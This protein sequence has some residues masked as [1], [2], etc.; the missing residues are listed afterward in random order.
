MAWIDRRFCG[1]SPCAAETIAA[2]FTAWRARYRRA[3]MPP[4]GALSAVASK[5][6]HSASSV[7][8][9]IVFGHESALGFDD[10][11]AEPLL[12]R[13][14][15]GLVPVD[16]R[17]ACEELRDLVRANAQAQLA[18]ATI[19]VPALFETLRETTD[20]DELV[21]LALEALF[22]SASAAHVM[23]DGTGELVKVKVHDAIAKDGGNIA[24]LIGELRGGDFYS[25]LYAAQTLSEVSETRGEALRAK[26]LGDPTAISTLMDATR[27]NEV[28][29]NEALLLL[30][31]L[32]RG[33]E[34]LQKLVAFE[35]AFERAFSIIAEEGGGDGGIVVQDCL[36]LCNNLLRDAPSNQTLFRENGF[37]RNV[38][39]LAVVERSIG[40]DGANV[41][42]AQKCANT[43]C[44]LET[45]HLLVSTDEDQTKREAIRVDAELEVMMI[46]QRI[47]GCRAN[48]TELAKY[49]TVDILIRAALGDTAVKVASVRIAALRA[50]AALVRDHDGNQTALFSAS[51]E[52]AGTVTEPALLSC[53]RTALHGETQSERDAAALV[54]GAAMRGNPEGQILLVSTLAPTGYGGPDGTD[55]SSLGG[56]L[57]R[58]LMPKNGAS[59]AFDQA[60]VAAAGILREMLHRNDQSRLKALRVNLEGVNARSSSSELLLPRCV[61][62]LA[63]TFTNEDDK[64]N[65]EKL[66][67]VFL[68]LLIV[69]LY[70]CAPAV[71]AFLSSPGHLPAIADLA[72][73]GGCT[74]SQHVAALACV[75]LGCC[76]LENS[77]TVLDVVSA[78]VGLQNFFM[79]WESMTTSEFYVNVSKKP[80]LPKPLTRANAS[81]LAN[82][83]CEELLEYAPGGGLYDHE[84]TIFINDLEER[85]KSSIMSLY[86]KP[87]GAADE[88]ATSTFAKRVDEDDAGYLVRLQQAL[89][90][91]QKD[92]SVAQA[93]NAVLA[94]QLLNGTRSDAPAQD[95][96]ARGSPES[97]ARNASTEAL[98]SAVEAAKRASA[99]EINAL[100][101]ELDDMRRLADERQESLTS[102]STAYNGLEAEVYRLEAESKGLREKLHA[103]ADS[104]GGLA[105]NTAALDVARDAGREEGRRL[106]EADVE[107]RMRDAVAAAL[108]E[109]T[110]AHE[111]ELNDL[112]ACLGQEEASKE[113]LYAKLLEL[114]QDESALEA[115]LAAIVIDDDDE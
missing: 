33:N 12:D 102:L 21:R 75:V 62:Q 59:M 55:E 78:R 46:Q 107:I 114:G 101:Q 113:H 10:G 60:S 95:H 84:I 100:K 73:T 1:A 81:N 19:G 30:V 93:R 36:E 35:G 97:G 9:N 65:V 50:L 45:I 69:W 13:I 3:T 39:A 48:Q 67:T 44:A 31:A 72:K 87:A 110:K 40:A 61:R 82:S 6:K 66:Q 57:A 88:P 29:R 16:R 86:A 24:Q 11:G 105:P 22:A 96:D 68:R 89:H 37:V 14:S 54:L 7:A 4:F 109:A 85:V 98:H 28:I 115:E 38:P 108:A 106:A 111:S 99:G 27:E 79:K 2:R 103:V 58:A 25:K 20:D 56:L 92:L 52:R 41:I 71:D 63:V 34:E 43:L 83:I 74:E 90:E 80:K 5:V 51:A 47:D 53:G 112:L 18:V 8:K 76:L 32:T 94:E 17:A 23:E 91:S 49:G 64:A 104:D 26:A 42:P 15:S 70:E 77:S